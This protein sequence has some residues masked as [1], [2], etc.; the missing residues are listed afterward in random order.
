MKTLIAVAALCLSSSAFAT[1]YHPANAPTREAVIKAAS[2][3]LNGESLKGARVSWSG[4]Q[5][6]VKTMQ[7]L[8]GPLRAGHSDMGFKAAAIVDF[9]GKKITNASPVQFAPVAL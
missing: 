2:K 1:G 8:G 6:T 4:D 3:A 5:A 9:A 7:F